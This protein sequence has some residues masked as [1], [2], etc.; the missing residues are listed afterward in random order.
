MFVQHLWQENCS[1]AA[2]NNLPKFQHPLLVFHSD[3]ENIFLSLFTIPPAKY[4]ISWSKLYS[5]LHN[6]IWDGSGSPT[7]NICF[8]HIDSQL[9][10]ILSPTSDRDRISPHII[11]MISRR[12]VMRI[13]KYINQGV[14]GWSNSK[15]SKLT[16]YKLYSRKKGELLMKSWESIKRINND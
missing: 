11:S 6:S 16:S 10:P 15:F 8:Q 2:P 13:K 1:P 4:C 7:H 5:Q 9:N 14:F 12:Q 3:L